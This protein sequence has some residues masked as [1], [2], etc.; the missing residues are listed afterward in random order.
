MKRKQQYHE[1]QKVTKRNTHTDWQSRSFRMLTGSRT[2][3]YIIF[4]SG[5]IRITWHRS[6]H[7]AWPEESASH[8][9]HITWPKHSRHF[10]HM[11]IKRSKIFTWQRCLHPAAHDLH[12]NTP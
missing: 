2:R 10:C 7:V 11:A 12:L 3:L 9:C 5:V 6:S 1:M 8:S 4:K